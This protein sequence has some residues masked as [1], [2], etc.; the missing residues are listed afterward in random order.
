MNRGG[1]YGSYAGF[2][3]RCGYRNGVYA[4]TMANAILGFRW[5]V[6]GVVRGGAFHISRTWY[7][8]C[9]GL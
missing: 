8:R 1:S 7:S 9:G 5:G 6:K 2:L 4:R 3:S